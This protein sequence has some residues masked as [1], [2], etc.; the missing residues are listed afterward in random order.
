MSP[1]TGVGL[2]EALE[3][4]ASALSAEADAIRPANGDPTALL[5]MLSAEGAG[6][7][8]RWLL[9]HEPEDGA[10]LAEAWAEDPERGTPVVLAVEE[11][12]LPKPARKE[13]RRLRH[14]MRSGG[15]AVPEAEPEPRRA[16][17][18]TVDEAIDEAML[19]P[20]DPRGSRAAFLVV[21]H[22]SGGVRV[23]ELVLDDLRGVLDCR[24][25]STGRSKVRRF[26]KE[27]A[28]GG[29]VAAVSAPP[30]A[31]RALV[32]RVAAA[33]AKDRPLPRGF[34][35]W[36]GQLTAGA[37]QASPPGALA[38]EA[39]GVPDEPEALARAV[40]LVRGSEVGP[41][42][43]ATEP[44]QALAQKLGEVA[45]SQVI[46]SPAARRERADGLV[47][48]ALAEQFAAPN[49]EGTAARFEETAYVLWRRG[50]D[51]DARACLA[52]ARAFREEA[53]AE[54]P[55]ARAML[56]VVLAPVLAKLDEEVGGGGAERVEP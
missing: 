17:L 21:S 37:E 44:L 29:R 15:V 28:S 43:P 14:R 50:R 7:V 53:P 8:L 9:E 48:D 16:T 1:P 56:E 41:W 39:L 10:E 18:P 24:V 12:G 30:A 23:F 6:R 55:V 52:A 49:D 19:S 27:F 3:R 38:R 54:N 51:D 45:E 40:A 35:E 25:Y 22:P 31:V 42:P 46:A 13:L 33:Q 34:S 5:G 2:P 26:L 11:A 4:A 36:R 32:A 20:L 47:S